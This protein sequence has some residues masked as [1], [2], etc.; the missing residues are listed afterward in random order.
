MR[1]RSRAASDNPGGPG[2]ATILAGL[3]S[4]RGAA[5][6]ARTSLRCRASRWAGGKALM[7]SP[8][9]R[10]GS[11]LPATTVLVGASGL[12]LPTV[13]T[14]PHASQRKYHTNAS[15]LEWS[16]NRG[17]ELRQWGHG[18]T[19]MAHLQ[20]V[21]LRRAFTSSNSELHPV[22]CKNRDRRVLWAIWPG[23]RGDYRHPRTTDVAYPVIATR[24][25]GSSSTAR[26]R[27]CCAAGVSPS[28]SSDSSERRSRATAWRVRL[29]AS[30]QV[31]VKRSAEAP[32]MRPPHAS[33]RGRAVPAPSPS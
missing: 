11:P 22:E 30:R 25:T 10:S 17:A 9:A 33:P 31:P 12:S 23:V 19:D 3:E 14:W 6:I 5:L 27:F 18:R 1:S 8:Y 16:S 2:R 15:A 24:A 7:A 28:S 20:K 29:R 26:A 32:S 13:K 21:R 4:E